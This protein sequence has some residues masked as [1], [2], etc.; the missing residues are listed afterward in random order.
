[1]SDSE[2]Q[3]LYVGKSVRVRTRLLSYFRAP[4]GEKAGELIRRTHRI[5]WEYLPNEFA[6]LLREM[7]QIKSWRPRYNVEHNRKRIY[8]FVKLTV[9]PAPRLIPSTRVVED[10][11]TYFGPFPNVSRVFSTIREL[12]LAL[13]LR[14][15]PASTPVFFGDQLEVFATGRAPRCMRAE[16]KSCL[17]PC[18]GLCTAG[19]YMSRVDAARDFLTGRG[20]GTVA[21][22]E[23]A[24]SAAAE[25]MDFEYAAL[26]RDRVERLRRLQADIVGLRGRVK[27]RTFLYRKPG[28]RGNNRLYLIRDGLVA[29]DFADPVGRRRRGAAARRIQLLLGGEPSPPRGLTPGQA[30]EIVL[31]GRWFRLHPEEARRTL[32]AAQW[33]ASVEAGEPP[34]WPTVRRPRQRREGNKKAEGVNH[35]APSPPRG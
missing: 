20:G 10:G 7:R 8:A 33:L 5:Q 26:L 15:C 23:E 34:Q 13:G 30:A 1:M 6:A 29:A 32:P 22:L 24:M 27:T 17:A 2:G 19:E 11:S 28:F 4:P 14:D 31:V 18:A 35:R 12:S 3:I 16:L 25:R 21:K 9:E